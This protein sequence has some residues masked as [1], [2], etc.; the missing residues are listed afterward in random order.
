MRKIIVGAFVSLDGVMQSPGGPGEDT[1]NGFGLGGWIVPLFDDVVAEA[2]GVL[3]G[4]SFDLLLGRKSY[5]ILGAHWPQA[6]KE[7]DPTGIQFNAITKYVAS[8]NPDADMHW[9]N[10]QHLGVDPIAAL[11]EI[12]QGDGPD[13]ITQGSP[14]F[15]QTLLGSDV[16]DEMTLMVFPI[17]LGTGK[18]LWRD[19]AMATGLELIDSKSSPKGVVISR[20]RRRGPIE[21]GSF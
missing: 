16:V 4:G 2:M 3:M 6:A 17:V 14:D 5:D 11:R 19:G 21:R 13:L 8:R 20:Y 7:G 12:K 15:V 18:R 1:S 10:S 9:Q